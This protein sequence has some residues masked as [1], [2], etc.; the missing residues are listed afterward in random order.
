MRRASDHCPRAGARVT[1][2]VAVLLGIAA[3][4]VTAPLLAQPS[5]PASVV[6]AAAVPDTEPANWAAP[7]ERIAGSVVAIKIDQTRA[8]DTEWNASAQATGF[9]VDAE[10]GLILTNPS[11]PAWT[12]SRLTP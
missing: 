4:L 6:R 9:V 8:F 10:R 7:L 12:P 11:P 2:L 3:P 1:G 5:K